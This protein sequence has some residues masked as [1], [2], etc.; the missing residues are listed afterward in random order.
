MSYHPLRL[1]A[2]LRVRYKGAFCGFL[3]I[4]SGGKRAADAVT[5]LKFAPQAASRPVR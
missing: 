2:A 4:R 3:H 5:T 1:G